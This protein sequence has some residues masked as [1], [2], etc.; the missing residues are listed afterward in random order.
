MKRHNV[1]LNCGAPLTHS[2]CDYCDTIYGR[3]FVARGTPN[4][5]VLV[6]DGKAI[7]CYIAGIETQTVVTPDPV[8]VIRKRKIVLIEH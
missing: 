1:C 8:T 4:N 6:I 5:I 2:T 7:N 3:D